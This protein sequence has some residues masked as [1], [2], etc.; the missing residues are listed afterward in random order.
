MSHHAILKLSTK[1][2]LEEAVSEATRSVG[3]LFAEGH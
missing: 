1:P 2:G 3:A